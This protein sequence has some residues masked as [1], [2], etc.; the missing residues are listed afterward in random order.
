MKLKVE[1]GVFQNE[2]NG[3]CVLACF[4]PKDRVAMVRYANFEFSSE[5]FFAECDCESCPAKNWCGRYEREMEEMADGRFKDFVL[6]NWDDI[7][8]GVDTHES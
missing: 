3:Y 5:M 4:D 6:E 1:K 7:V 2:D 8:N